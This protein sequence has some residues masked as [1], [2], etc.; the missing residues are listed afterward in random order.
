MTDTI[1]EAI[2]EAV[3][4][5]RSRDL[6]PGAAA[7][8]MIRAVRVLLQSRSRAEIETLAVDLTTWNE[9]VRMHV[10]AGSAGGNDVVLARRILPLLFEAA[11]VLD[12]DSQAPTPRPRG[13]HF[14][15]KLAERMA[16]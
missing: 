4:R 12:T 13:K 3:Q 5:D 15:A 14:A 7:Q 9:A 10:R 2:V 8:A 1:Y 6:N 16:A 11:A